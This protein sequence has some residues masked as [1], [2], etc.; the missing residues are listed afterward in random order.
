[1]GARLGAHAARLLS[2]RALELVVE[3]DLRP[4]RRAGEQQPLSLEREVDLMRWY[5]RSS[6]R[7]VRSVLR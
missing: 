1:V 5:I 4:L 6:T 7:I 3:V 2:E